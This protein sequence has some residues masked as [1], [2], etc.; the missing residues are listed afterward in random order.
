MLNNSA[1][2]PILKQISDYLYNQTL[3]VWYM[4][5][6]KNN[7]SAEVEEEMKEIEETIQVL[8]KR[9]PQEAEKFRRDIIINY[10]ERIKNKF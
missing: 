3:R 10:V 2:N 4:V 8:S 6:E 7:F 5:F 9:D 1:D